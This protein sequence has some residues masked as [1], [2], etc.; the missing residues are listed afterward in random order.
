MSVLGTDTKAA[1]KEASENIKVMVVQPPENSTEEEEEEGRKNLRN[2]STPSVE[3]QVAA[4][5]D[6]CQ[7]E[8]FAVQNSPETYLQDPS[9]GWSKR[10]SP[11]RRSHHRSIDLIPLHG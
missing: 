4:P 1:V 9:Q 3:V 8:L 11:T 7:A 5:Y 2:R 6:R 10:Y